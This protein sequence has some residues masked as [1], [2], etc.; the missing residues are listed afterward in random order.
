MPVQPQVMITKKIKKMA[1]E[2]GNEIPDDLVESEFKS[3]QTWNYSKRIFTT[4]WHMKGTTLP[5][6]QFYLLP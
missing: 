5:Q 2:A 1:Q 4:N 3:T 6:T